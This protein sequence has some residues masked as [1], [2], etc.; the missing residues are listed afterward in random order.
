MGETEREPVAARLGEHLLERCRQVEVVVHLVDVEG[1]VGACV[2]GS[3]GAG[4]RR[5]PDAR[6]DERAEQPRGVLAER[7]LRHPHQ[8]QATI[9]EAAGDVDR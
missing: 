5:L 4:E 3:G 6:H 9:V 8:Q 1:A 2:F 7:P